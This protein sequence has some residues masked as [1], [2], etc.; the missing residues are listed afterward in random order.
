MY[1]LLPITFGIKPSCFVKLP[2]GPYIP[3]E[4][5][6]SEYKNFKKEILEKE[7]ELEDADGNLMTAEQAIDFVK[8]LK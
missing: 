4:P 7:A 2:Y 1:K 6:N 5:A 3:F 8:T